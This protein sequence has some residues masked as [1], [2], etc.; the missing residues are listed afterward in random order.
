MITALCNHLINSR[1]KV[2][3]A[4]VAYT[5]PERRTRLW[6]RAC[7]ITGTTE[8]D[9]Q[10]SGLVKKSP[11]TPSIGLVFT[12]RGAQW[13]QMGRDLVE[14]FP[15]TRSILEEPDHVLKPSPMRQN[16]PLLPN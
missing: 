6:H 9:E 14:Y 16:G 11:K 5:L 15:W 10:D 2:H 1:I 3:L 8:L 4:D 12:G 7:I 13:P